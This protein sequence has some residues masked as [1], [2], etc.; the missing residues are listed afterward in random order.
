MLVDESK[1]FNIGK[2]K[3]YL[4][5]HPVDCISNN[6]VVTNDYWDM[7]AHHYINNFLKDD[8]VILDIGANIGSHTLYWA[9]ERKA[10]K[11]YAFEPLPD[12]FEILQKNIELNNLQKTVKLFECGLSDEECRQDIVIFNN[13]NIGGTNFRKNKNGGFKFRSLDSFGIKEHIDLIKID[14]EGEEVAVLNGAKETIERSHPVIVIETF[15]YK[16]IIDNFMN[17]RS[18]TLVATIRQNEDYIYKYTG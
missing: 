14:V 18:Y 9:I 16:Y 12:T 8:A 13:N 4:P 3:F 2:A 5:H 17:E 11:I 10:K 1:I 15:H 7:Q 6:I